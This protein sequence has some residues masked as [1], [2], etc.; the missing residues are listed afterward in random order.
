MDGV[1]IV[2]KITLAYIIVAS[3]HHVIAIVDFHKLECYPGFIDLPRYNINYN[4]GTSKTDDLS[5]SE[6]RTVPSK[7]VDDD[8]D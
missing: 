4:I 5:H 1:I 2:S 6:R 8:E 3:C 7:W